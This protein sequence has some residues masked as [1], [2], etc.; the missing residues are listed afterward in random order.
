[1]SEYF[2]KF[3]M[4]KCG[5]FTTPYQ[6]INILCMLAS[7]YAGISLKGESSVRF[8]LPQ[9]AGSSASFCVLRISAFSGICIRYEIPQCQLR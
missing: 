9:S 4:F 2:A 8:F 7:Q 5:I 3:F 6:L 1:M